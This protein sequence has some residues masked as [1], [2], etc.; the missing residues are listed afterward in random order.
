MYAFFRVLVNKFD[1]LLFISSLFP[2]HILT[3]TSDRD[4]LKVADGMSLLS[5]HHAKLK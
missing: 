4:N 1:N 3:G 5:S 2:H